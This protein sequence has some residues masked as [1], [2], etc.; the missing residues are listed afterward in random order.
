MGGIKIEEWRK[1]CLIRVMIK[2]NLQCGVVM[3]SPSNTDDL[4]II[5][6]VEPII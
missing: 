5:D 2:M 3:L 6:L 4:H 1:V